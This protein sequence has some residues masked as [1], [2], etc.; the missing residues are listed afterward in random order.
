VH[1]PFEIEEVEMNPRTFLISGTLAATALLLA[2][3]AGAASGSLGALQKSAQSVP[4]QVTTV[5]HGGPMMGM[6][7]HSMGPHALHAYSAP[8]VAHLHHH[9]HRFFVGVP[10][11]DYN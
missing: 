7:V 8:H 6:H 11:Y 5:R 3:A 9:H 4:S 2:G 10:Y 1:L